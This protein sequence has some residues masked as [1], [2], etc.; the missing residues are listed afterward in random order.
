MAHAGLVELS[1]NKN[2]DNSLLPSKFFGDL[3]IKI[4]TELL[5]QCD[6]LRTVFY[7]AYLYCYGGALC[8]C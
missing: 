5:S 2:S 1:G 3:C 4:V 7:Y 6:Y 8:H